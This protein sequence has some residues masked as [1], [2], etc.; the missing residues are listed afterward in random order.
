M[1]IKIHI[2]IIK[3]NYIATIFPKKLLVNSDY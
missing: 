2:F 1:K 3:L